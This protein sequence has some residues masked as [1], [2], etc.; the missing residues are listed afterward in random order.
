VP[1]ELFVITLS[2]TVKSFF[3]KGS[4]F[5]QSEI[6]LIINILDMEREPAHQGHR[7]QRLKKELL[8]KKFFIITLL[9]LFGGIGSGMVISYYASTQFE[10]LSSEEMYEQIIDY[11]NSA[12]KKATASGIYN[13]CITPACTMCYMEANQ[14]NNR[15][16]GTCACEDLIAQGKEI[17]PQCKRGI[18]S[19]KGKT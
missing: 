15:T 19:L 17:C 16:P 12:I 14:W 9:V 6:L 4:Q 13:C 10:D 1:V 7:F 18:E 5:K 2:W 8:I 3:K 11:R